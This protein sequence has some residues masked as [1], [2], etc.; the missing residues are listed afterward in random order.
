[1]CLGVFLFGL[2]PFGT[3]CFLNVNLFSFHKSGKFSA[4]IS[5]NTFSVPF[6]FSSLSWS[7]I[8]CMLVYLMLSQSFLKLFSFLFIFFG[9]HSS[10]EISLKISTLSPS[11]LMHS[12]APFNLLLIPSSVFLFQLFFISLWFFFKNENLEFSN[13]L[14]KTY[15]FSSSSPVSSSCLMLLFISMCLVGWLHLLT[16]K[17]WLMHSQ[18]APLFG[19]QS[20]IL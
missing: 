1:M 7:L 11:S 3:P 9:Y 15:N 13:T 6:S 4:I 16:L 17:K 2:I 8:M 19:H 5:S 18:S 14:L 12:S 20:Y 10:S